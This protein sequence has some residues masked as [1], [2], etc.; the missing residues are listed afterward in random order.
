MTSNSSGGFSG[1][2]SVQ[3]HQPRHREESITRRAAKQV[4]PNI[5]TEQETGSQFS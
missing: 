1:K 2:K 4:K 5:T 3:P